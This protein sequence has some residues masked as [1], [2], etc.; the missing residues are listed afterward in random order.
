MFPIA[1]GFY[2]IWFAPSS[3]PMYIHWKGEPWGSI[4]VSIL[5][6]GTQRGASMPNVL[7]KDADGLI[8]MVPLKGKKSC[9]LRYDWINCDMVLRQG[10]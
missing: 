10:S 1:P 4:F 8:N 3:T 2:P 6:L 7:K 9:E 5:Q